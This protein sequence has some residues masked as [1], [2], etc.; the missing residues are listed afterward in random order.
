MIRLTRSKPSSNVHHFYALQV[1][2]IFE[3]E[4]A[5]QAAL[6]KRLR[7]KTRRGYIQASWETA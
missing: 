1:A 3:T 2:P 5:A 6:T 4:P 7:I